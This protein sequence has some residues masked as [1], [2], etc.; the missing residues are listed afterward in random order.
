MPAKLKVGVVFGGRSG[1]HEVSLMSSA[2]VMKYI[3]AEKYEVVPLGITK[4]G[5][6]L[7]E[8]NPWEALKK[9]TNEHGG[10]PPTD[11][12]STLDVVFPV[13]HGPYGEDGTI[14]GL[15][16]MCGVP[17]VGAG[18]LASAVGMDKV[19][20]KQVF[21]AN[22]FPIARYL[23]VERGDWENKSGDISAQ[24]Q[25]E[26]GLPVFV[27]PANLGSSVG[28]S[29]ARTEDELKAAIQL[30]LEYDRRIMVEEYIPCREFECAILG[31]SNPAASVIGE[32]VPHKEFYDYEAKYTDGVS[33]LIIPAPVP[34]AVQEQVQ[35]LG[36][37]AYKAIDC[38][39][40][41]RVDFFMHR[42]TG[43]VLLNE[44]NTIPGFTHLSMYPRLW[45][46]SGLNYP[47]LIDRL[48]ILAR[49]RF[50]ERSRLRV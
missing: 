40:M 2:S 19:I 14:Q 47:E 10:P 46:A 27:K 41:A 42:E 8:G 4:S 25:T 7:T 3:P 5:G 23:T 49:E 50:S 30:A 9:G 6:W 43:Q 11:L 21:Q 44:V 13:L 17:Y 36:I 48:I 35:A 33:D 12:L 24:I 38:A 22:G 16:E 20:Q 45:E 39:G 1:E 15:F 34:N 31:N 18:V 28:V 26:L 32:I 37:A 29:K